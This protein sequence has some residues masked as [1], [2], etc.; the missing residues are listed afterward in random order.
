[1][2]TSD[3]VSVIVTAYNRKEYLH[4][5][6]QSLEQQSVKAFETILITNF[7][8]DI[9]R[10]NIQIKHFQQDSTIGDFLYTGV[11]N[12]SHEIVCFL[13]DD[14]LFEAN[15]IETISKEFED[16][17][18]VYFHNNYDIIEDRGR[19]TT[20]LSK[21]HASANLSAISVRKSIIDIEILKSTWTAPDDLMYLFAIRSGLK[22]VVSLLKLSFYRRYSLNISA[23]RRDNIPSMK[24]GLQQL[25][26]YEKYFQDCPACMKHINAS[27][28]HINLVIDAVSRQRF[29]NLFLTTFRLAVNF[30]WVLLK[31]ML[32]YF[33][34]DYFRK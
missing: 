12:S 31:V 15:K 17:D 6:L 5:A 9:H 2:A 25:T 19:I 26:E 27:K 21:S 24:Y 13:D 16:S 11:T 4:Y 8:F 28:S 22:I 29:P 10:Y 23:N 18:V 33:I 34:S 7:P 3:G 1:M 14:D 30:D 32:K 20:L